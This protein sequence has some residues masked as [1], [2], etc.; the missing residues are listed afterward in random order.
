MG[1]HL[2]RLPDGHRLV[3]LA[4]KEIRADPSLAVV[5]DRV[6]FLI[7]LRPLEVAGFIRNIPVE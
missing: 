7:E 1:D 4:P 2:R 3:H 6:D 5:D